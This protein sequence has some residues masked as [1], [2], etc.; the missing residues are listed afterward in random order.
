VDRIDQFVDDLSCIL[1]GSVGQMSV[2]GC[3]FGAAVAEDSLDV[4]D[5]QAFFQQMGCKRVPQGVDRDF[6]L[7]PHCST[8]A[9]M[10]A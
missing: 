3:G 5:V 8:T 9:F 10:A 4:T 7:M 2:A 1:F 6:F